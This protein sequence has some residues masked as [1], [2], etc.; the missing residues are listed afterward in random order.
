LVNTVVTDG[1]SQEITQLEEAVN[2]YFPDVYRFRYSWHTIDPGWHKKVKVPLG[3]H[4]RKK[5]PLRLKGIKSKKAP[6]LTESNKTARTIYRWI[7]SWAQ[8]TYCESE[9][10]FHY[11]CSVIPGP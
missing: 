9:G 1:D 11:L 4:A 5:M 8:P 3:G 10:S 7:F 2:K 6:P